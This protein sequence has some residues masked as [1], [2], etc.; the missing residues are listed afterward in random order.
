MESNLPRAPFTSL[1]N[2]FSLAAITEA[3]LDGDRKINNL[4]TAQSS[5]RKKK[6]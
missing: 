2:S 3:L 1:T 4:K 6:L 5:K